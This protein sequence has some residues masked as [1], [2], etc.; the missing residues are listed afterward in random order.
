G[1]LDR[2]PVSATPPPEVDVVFHLAANIDTDTPES[3]HRVNDLGTGR[4]LDWLAPVLP[5]CRVVYTSS[6]AVIDR[7]GTADGPMRED[8]VCTPRTA[9]GATKLRGEAILR[10]RT[11][12]AASTWTIVRL[13]T[14][15]GPGGKPGGMFDLLVTAARNRT[16]VSRLN[17]PGRTSI[18]LLDGPGA[19]PRPL[20]PVPRA[21]RP[22]FPPS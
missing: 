19:M 16:L 2:T 14:V 13:P 5:G 12:A 17:W 22:R 9:Y 1:D 6:V 10:E 11:A 18:L 15:Y 7:A 20:A 3:E 21:R 4:L 8:T